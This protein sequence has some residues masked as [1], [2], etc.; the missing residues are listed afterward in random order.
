MKYLY[1][2]FLIFSLLFI[3]CSSIYTISNYSSKEKYYENI[4][5]SIKSRDF[6]IALTNDSLVTFIDGGVIKNDTLFSLLNVLPMNTVKNIS[7]KT[8]WRSS[9]LGIIGGTVIGTITGIVIGK[10]LSSKDDSGN[11]AA[12]Y[13][14]GP[15]IGALFGGVIG[16]AIGWNTIYKIHPEK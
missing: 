12:Y 16:W 11:Q 3:G 13:I 6:E 8:K 2:L 10:S 7:Y 1:F 15:P 5:Q 9:T 4:N 14:L